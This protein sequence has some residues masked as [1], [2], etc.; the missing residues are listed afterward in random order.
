MMRVPPSRL[1][2]ALLV[3]TTA[4]LAAGA[5]FGIAAGALAA[6]VQYA[7]VLLAFAAVGWFVARHR[8]RNPIGWLFLVE[9][10]AFAV[11]AATANYARYAISTGSRPAAA[12]WLAW[13]GAIPG[14]LFFLL[15]LVLLVFPDG[16]VPSRRWRPVAWVIVTAEVV[17]VAI[18]ALSGAALRGQ[19]ST[20]RSPVNLIPAGAAYSILQF[21][22]T[23]MIPVSLVA[24]A[25]CVSRY[26]RSSA[27]VR[28]QIKWVAFPAC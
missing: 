1:A 14:E 18:A 15:A 11:A 16:Q 4:A 10:L 19:G 22:Q 7:P 12:A 2:A 8:P 23:V 5:G 3:V 20:V 21:V 17:T 26:R 13:L 6:A 27:E 9:A 28:H 24:A 25:G